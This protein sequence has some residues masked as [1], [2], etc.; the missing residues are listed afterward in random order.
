MKPTKKRPSKKYANMSN[1]NPII[2]K[3]LKLKYKINDAYRS[4]PHETNRDDKTWVM[5]LIS[6]VR[7]H[8]LHKLSYEDGLKCNALWRSYEGK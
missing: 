3:L 8:D 5:T 4:Y 6:D 2:E 7:E 1:G